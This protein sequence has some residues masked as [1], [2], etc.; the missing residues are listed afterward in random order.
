MKT[1]RGAWFSGSDSLSLTQISGFPAW[2]RC[3]RPA[4]CLSF[5]TCS[6]G[7][8][9]AAHRTIDCEVPR[10]GASGYRSGFRGKPPEGRWE[11]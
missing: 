8:M 1:S 9:R 6:T 5:P 10:M 3:D 2:G 4:P 7:I 11:G